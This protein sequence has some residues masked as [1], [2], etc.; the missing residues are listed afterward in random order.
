MIG[1]FWS[2]R[3]GGGI[4]K[5]MFNNYFALDNKKVP[6]HQPI[7][8]NEDYQKSVA[9]IQTFNGVGSDPNKNF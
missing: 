5:D 8:Q 6:L 9:L 2:K 4:L 3:V 7:K 1:K